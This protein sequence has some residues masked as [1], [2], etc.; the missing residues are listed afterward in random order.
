MSIVRYIKETRAE[1][2]HVTWP[3]KRQAIGYSVA[4]VL[5]SLVIAY[6]LGALDFIFARGLSAILGF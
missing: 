1:F 4:V 6:F 3:T 2:T 5:I